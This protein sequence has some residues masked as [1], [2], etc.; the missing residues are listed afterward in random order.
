M[1]DKRELSPAQMEFIQQLGAAYRAMGTQERLS[2]ELERRI[3]QR[4]GVRSIQFWLVGKGPA[5][6][7]RVSIQTELKKIIAAK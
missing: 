1:V 3:G 6:A 7:R 4:I 5:Q 2:L